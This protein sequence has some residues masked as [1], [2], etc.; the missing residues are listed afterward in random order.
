M[1]TRVY[2]DHAALSRGAA[3]ALAQAI[4]EKPDLNIVVATGSTPMDSYAELAAMQ[5]RGEVNCRRLHVFQLDAYLDVADD[6]P[7]SLYGWMK[8]SFLDPLEIPDER[9]FRMDRG[10]A[11]PQRN[12]DAHAALVRAR[13]G[14]DIA[15]LGLGP[16]GHLAFNEPP[17]MRDAP[18][19]VV[20]LSEESIVSNARYWGGRDRV[21]PLSVTAGMDLLLA[22][23]TLMLLVSGEGK[24]EIL[25]RTMAGPVTPMVPSSYIRETARSLV[26]A[27][28]AALGE[29]LVHA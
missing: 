18:T 27:D 17:S 1:K 9:V 21:P 15:V 4:G 29:S 3:L 23:K 5:R 19:R 7:R 11:D 10:N 6:D 25:R 13:G 24:R 12:C 20:P 22:A 2:D 14:Y 26:L 16:N 28:K 8:R